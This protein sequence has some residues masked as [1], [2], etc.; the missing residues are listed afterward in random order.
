MR[1]VAQAE[2][3]VEM[4][5]RGGDA[6]FPVPRWNDNRKK[7][8]RRR[9]CG[10]EAESSSQLGCFSAWSAISPR[11]FTNGVA[12]CQFQ[13]LAARAESSTS[14]G[15][16]KGRVFGSAAISRGPKRFAHQALS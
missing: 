2:L 12:T 5:D 8:K 13:S 6:I 11:I 16:S 1:H 15:M 9:G 14:H 10:H 4:L 7:R 3:D